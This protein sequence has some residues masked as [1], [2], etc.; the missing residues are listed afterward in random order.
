MLALLLRSIDTFKLFDKV[1][2]LTGGGPGYATETLSLYIYQQ[3]FKFF[4]L[5]LASAGAVI[6]LLFAAAMSLVYAWQLLRGGKSA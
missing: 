1:Y 6:M 5:G 4:N 3:G 2:A